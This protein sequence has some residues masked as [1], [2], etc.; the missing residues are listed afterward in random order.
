MYRFWEGASSR[1][2]YRYFNVPRNWCIVYF[3]DL[4]DDDDDDD[5]DDDEL[6]LQDG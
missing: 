1:L 5:D 3:L 2:G 4:N 6:L